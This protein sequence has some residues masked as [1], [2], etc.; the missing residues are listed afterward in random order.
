MTCKQ[1][2]SIYFP[3]VELPRDGKLYSKGTT[4]KCKKPG[5]NED[6]GKGLNSTTLAF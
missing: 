6:S 1:T 2:T 3:H 5:L 4:D